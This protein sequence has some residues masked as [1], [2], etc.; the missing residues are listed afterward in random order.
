MKK[1]FTAILF[2]LSVSANA[3]MH[4]LNPNND[5]S[6][7]LSKVLADYPNQFVNIKGTM[8][9]QDVQTTDYTCSVNIPNA[10]SSVI[11][12]TGA[13]KDHVYSWKTVLLSTDDYNKAK[14]KF[15]E[16]Y[17]RVKTASASIGGNKITLHG[18]YEGPDDSKRFATVLLTPAPETGALK[19][20]V[21]DLSMQYVLSIWQI[22]VSVYE[23]K[24]YGVDKQQTEG[25]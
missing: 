12:Q 22:S 14:L 13:E 3:Q 21:V 17:S 2:I 19:D 24:D 11:T 4:L 5:I 1:Y 8:I 9:D 16:Y 10:D 25:N 20:V 15:H 6:N 7:A 23:H 18:D